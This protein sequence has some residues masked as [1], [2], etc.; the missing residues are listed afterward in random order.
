MFAKIRCLIKPS[1]GNVL[2]NFS[3]KSMWLKTICICPT[4]SSSTPGWNCVCMCYLHTLL[5]PVWW[6]TCSSMFIAALFFLL[7]NLQ[8]AHLTINR[9]LIN[10]GLVIQWNTVSVKMNYAINIIGFLIQNSK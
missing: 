8:R 9:E 7:L 10:C 4:L 2:E 5:G 6:D 3:L 1:V